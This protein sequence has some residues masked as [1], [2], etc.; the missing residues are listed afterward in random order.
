MI[1]NNASCVKSKLL[2]EIV[3]G[4]VDGKAMAKKTAKDVSGE[5]N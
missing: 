5:M 3:A 1:A 2:C 4:V